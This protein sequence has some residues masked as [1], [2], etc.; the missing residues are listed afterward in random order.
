MENENKLFAIG[1]PTINRAD[2]LNEALAKYVVDFPTTRIL[3]VDN[4]DQEIMTHANITT[5]KMPENVGVAASWNLICD[6][7][8]ND[9]DRS[10]ALTL[11]D[12][13]YLGQ[14]QDRIKHLILNWQD[15]DFITTAGTWCAFIMRKRTFEKV[16]RFDEEF[17]PA[18]FE[19]NDF[20]YR[21]KLLDLDVFQ[22]KTLSPVIYRNSMTIAKDPKL[23][24]NYH[25]NYQRYIKKWGGTVGN[26]KFKTPFDE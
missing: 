4:G 22:T 23:N 10:A 12:D 1:I 17:T 14:T 8:F 2:L 3:V 11:N 6:T 25:T 20:S 16:G 19:D 24:M 21:M 9:W 13:I 5:M 7:I 26:E 15:E 18:Y